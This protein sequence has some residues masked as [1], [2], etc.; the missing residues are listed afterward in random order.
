MPSPTAG[1]PKVGAGGSASHPGTPRLMAEML[2]STSPGAKVGSVPPGLKEEEEMV[3]LLDEGN[4]MSGSE[5]DRGGTAVTPPS[6]RAK[7]RTER[8]RLGRSP[9]AHE[10]PGL[11]DAA[12]WLWGG[13]R[14]SGVLCVA[15]AAAAY[16][17][18]TPLVKLLSVRAVPLFETAAVRCAL[19]ALLS[20]AL[21]KRMGHPILGAPPARLLLLARAAAGF[22]A[23]ASFFYSIKMLP[24]RDATVLNFTI[25]VW[26]AVVARI[27]LKERW[28]AKELFGTLV[29]FCGVVLTVQPQMLF[30][31]QALVPFRDAMDAA[32]RK[33]SLVA[34]AGAVASAATGGVAYCLVRAVG[35]AGEPPLANVFAFAA[36]SV[37]AAALCSLLFEKPVVLGPMELIGMLCVGFCAFAAQVLLTRGLQ[38]E[39]AGKACSMLYFKVPI[40]YALGVLFFKDTPTIVS[41]AGAIVVVLSAL[42][43]ASSR[44]EDMKE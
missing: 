9:S 11:G 26:A 8:R 6:K 17:L 29:C 4:P 14:H 18:M 7:E 28:S 41:G 20:A 5:S 33:E 15:A 36:L 22:L 13:S 25:P 39:R 16:A 37:P 23:L 21:L 43:I 40:S 24:L 30:G 31:A 44:S 34:I 27:F 2:A 19:I 10:G 3:G 38:L 35:R 1:A 42:V 32:K 12:R